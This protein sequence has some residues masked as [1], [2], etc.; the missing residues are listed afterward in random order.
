[1]AALLPHEYNQCYAMMNDCC[2]YDD[3]A[4]NNYM[5]APGGFMKTLQK[6]PWPVYVGGAVGG[7]FLI[8][9]A[10]ERHR[11]NQAAR[12]LHNQALD[13]P[14]SQWTLPGGTP[15]D[16]G[17]NN[18]ANIATQIYNAYGPNDWYSDKGVMMDLLHQIPPTNFNF[19]AAYY[20]NT[21]NDDLVAVY[22][23]AMKG[24]VWLGAWQAYKNSIHS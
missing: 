19:I 8:N 1:M 23:R 15:Q 5:S 13:L 10:I 2:Q 20:K 18:A 14:A 12:D 3:M 7:Y 24:T 6:I 4:N 11:L 21:F 16:S 17:A 9:N 22:D